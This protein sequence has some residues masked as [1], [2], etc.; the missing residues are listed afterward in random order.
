MG[1]PPRYFRAGVGA[2]ILDDSGQALAFERSRMPGA[3]QFPQG[4]I[5]AGEEPLD[6]V[7][8]EVKEETGLTRRDLRLV[9]AYPEPLVYELPPATQRRKTGMGQVQYWFFFRMR[10]PQDRVMVP[11]D[12][13][14]R[15]AAWIPFDE[16]VGRAVS[17]RRRVYERLRDFASAIGR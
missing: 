2:V 16:A 10:T 1:A 17:F 3:W 13:E 9:A 8:R 11:P 7:W 6:A 5:E 15:Q 14:F 12:G 4:G